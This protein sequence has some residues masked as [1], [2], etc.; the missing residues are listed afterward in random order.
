MLFKFICCLL[1]WILTFYYFVTLNKVFNSEKYTS[2]QKYGLFLASSIIGFVYCIPKDYVPINTIISILS[3]FLILKFI[4]KFKVIKSALQTLSYLLLSFIS[5]LIAYLFVRLVVIDK[6][7]FIYTTQGNI[8]LMLIYYCIIFIIT[9][10][11]KILLKKSDVYTMLK[12]LKTKQFLEFVLLTV[13][14]IFPQLLLLA[15]NKYEYQISFLIFNIIQ[16]LVITIYML[17]TTYNYLEKEKYREENIELH[18]DN[19]AMSNL[20]D[21]I[22]TV[23]HDFNNIFQAIHG[24][25]CVK[26]YVKLE[27]YVDSIMKECNMLNNITFLNKE[28]FDDPG[29]YGVIGSKHFHATNLGILFEIDV[30]RKISSINFSKASLCRIFGIILDNAIEATSKVSDKYIKLEIHFDKVK[31]ANVIKV[32]NTYDTNVKINLPQIFEKGYSSKKIKS[33]IGLWEVKKLISNNKKSQIYATIEND[34]FV[35]NIIIED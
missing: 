24:Y 9:S 22:R 29:V 13:L 19:K 31:N 34:L 23:K 5:E 21:G 27:E 7:S 10:L 25:I 28:V 14:T 1:E 6:S 26:D 35:Q 33:G 12:F 4:L 32:Y 30:T 16:I 18:T 11:I 17:Y 15:Y 2:K 8:T 20:I 3:L